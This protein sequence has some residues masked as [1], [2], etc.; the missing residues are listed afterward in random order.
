[1]TWLQP[2]SCALPRGVI[3]EAGEDAPCTHWR[4]FY[5]HQHI[6]GVDF[7]LWTLQ[8]H[9]SVE[10]AMVRVFIRTTMHI[11]VIKIEHLV[12]KGVDLWRSSACVLICVTAGKKKRTHIITLSI[13][14]ICPELWVSVIA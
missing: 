12:I 7:H 2:G 1:M 8:D 14:N 6:S 10:F 11:G 3:G 13:S 5:Q 4:V 9:Q